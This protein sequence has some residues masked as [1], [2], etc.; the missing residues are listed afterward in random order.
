VQTER[1]KTAAD[2]SVRS[3]AYRMVAVQA[4]FVLILAV[5]WSFFSGVKTLYSVLLGG[6][7][8]VLPGFWFARRLFKT[9]RP[10]ALRRIVLTFLLGECVKLVMSAVLLVCVIRFLPV[11]L[12]PSIL[13]FVIALLGFWFAPLFVKMDVISESRYE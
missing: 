8:V 2:Q 9:T 7:A 12:L 4:L 13:G 1:K 10:Q 3:I 6:L 5:A 11:I